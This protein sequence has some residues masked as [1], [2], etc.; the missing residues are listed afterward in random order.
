MGASDLKGFE[1]EVHRPWGRYRDLDV[2]AR[3][4]VKRITVE[5]GQKLSLQ[6]HHHRAEHW[7]I[8]SG[9]GRVT[10]GDEVRLLT[11]NES[12]YIAIGQLHRLENPGK[13]PLQLIE[14]QVGAYVGE[15]DIVR[16]EDIYRRETGNGDPQEK[17][18]A[19]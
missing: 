5:P 10:C 13:V 6:Y 17:E 16:V 1:P 8:V 19:R 7:V 3:F 12:V 15:D 18:G 14:V 2:G 4:R 9:T 11:E